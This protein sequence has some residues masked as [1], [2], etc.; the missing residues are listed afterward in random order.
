M[1]C[2][3]QALIFIFW[4]KIKK[5]IYL[6][7]V[8]HSQKNEPEVAGHESQN[9]GSPS[10]TSSQETAFNGSDWAP[11]HR[12]RQP[13]GQQAEQEEDP[14]CNQSRAVLYEVAGGPGE[15]KGGR[16]T[17]EYSFIGCCSGGTG[18]P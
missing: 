14:V 11:R 4:G 13:G 1:F 2:Q 5:S 17:S 3:Q 8:N 9:F 18:A 12:P 10:P 6:C 7:N 15:G 16:Q